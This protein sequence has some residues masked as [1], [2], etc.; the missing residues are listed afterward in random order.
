MVAAARRRRR[1]HALGGGARA[2]APGARWLRV[3]LRGAG[4]ALCASAGSAGGEL[5]G[6]AH[7]LESGCAAE[8]PPRRRAQ[9]PSPPARG[10]GGLQEGAANLP[11][12][13]L[14]LLRSARRN[15]GAAAA[16]ARGARPRVEAGGPWLQKRVPR[17]GAG[18]PASAQRRCDGAPGLSCWRLGSFWSKACSGRG[19]ALRWP[20]AAAARRGAAPAAAVRC[21]LVR[22]RARVWCRGRKYTVGRT[23]WRRRASAHGRGARRARPKIA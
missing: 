6:S 15:L 22:A 16:G 8:A 10:G 1:V 4:A 2:A 17:A 19:R 20:R 7:V 23:A 14:I 18:R 13:L 11:P 12:G 3:V 9:M 21:C 5:R